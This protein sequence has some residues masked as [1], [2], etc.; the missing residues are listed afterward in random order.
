M[1]TALKK[2]IGGGEGRLK[3]EIN[4]MKV[5]ILR[6]DI[7]QTRCDAIINASNTRLRLGSG[8]SGAI[9]RAAGPGLQNDMLSHAPLARG[10][11]VVT[12][13]CVDGVHSKDFTR[14]HSQWS[15]RRY[16]PGML[17]NFR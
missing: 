8:V 17:R 6:G 3:L 2:K 7:T 13:S 1:A 5:V 14:S 9:R 15:F 12:S 10:A 16:P 4:G 11:V